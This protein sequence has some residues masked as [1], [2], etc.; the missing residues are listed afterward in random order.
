[1]NVLIK[2]IKKDPVIYVHSNEDCKIT[3]K[4][5]IQRKK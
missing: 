4:K 2:K 3:L 1:M 5:T